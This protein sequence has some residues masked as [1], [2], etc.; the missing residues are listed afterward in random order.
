MPGHG[1]ALH[2][3]SSTDHESKWGYY[4]VSIRG[5]S[6]C[7]RISWNQHNALQEHPRSLS[8]RLFCGKPQAL[9]NMKIHGH[10]RSPREFSRSTTTISIHGPFS[11][12]L[13][14]RGNPLGLRWEPSIMV[15]V[16]ETFRSAPFRLGSQMGHKD[17]RWFLA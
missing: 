5:R 6:R 14:R 16:Q 2:L 10:H 7:C 3:P 12:A 9:L 4:F 1:R 11:W 15:G 13:S 8:P 17:T